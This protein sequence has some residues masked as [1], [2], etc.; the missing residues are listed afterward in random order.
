MRIWQIICDNNKKQK[1]SHIDIFRYLSYIFTYSAV[2]VKAVFSFVDT[3]DD[4]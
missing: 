3:D 4:D 2:V 1:I